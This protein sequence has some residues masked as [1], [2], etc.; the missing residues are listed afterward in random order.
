MLFLRLIPEREQFTRLSEISVDASHFFA[1]LKLKH[2]VRDPYGRI[3]LRRIF[4][5][6]NTS[7]WLG[8]A[9]LMPPIFFSRLWTYVW[10][11]DSISFIDKVAYIRKMPLHV[12]KCFLLSFL[13]IVSSRKLLSSAICSILFIKGPECI[14]CRS[15]WEFKRTLYSIFQ[16]HQI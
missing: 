4:V 6:K 16:R 13:F 10:V 12:S 15:S 3:R 9:L 5:H 11:Q 2:F 14:P 1:M 8:Q 7:C